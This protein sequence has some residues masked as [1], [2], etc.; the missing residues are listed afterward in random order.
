MLKKIK[1]RSGRHQ[2]DEFQRWVGVKLICEWFINPTLDKNDPPWLMEEIGVREYGIFDD[3]LMYKDSE[4]NFFQI[5]H[6]LS[7]I[8]DTIEL[9]DLNKENKKSKI[10]IDEMYSSYKKIQNKIESNSFNLIIYSNKSI[11]ST[12]KKKI[13][14]SNGCFDINFKMGNLKDSEKI[15]IR[16]DFYDLCGKPE[17]FEKFLDKLKFIKS[18]FD[19]EL[20]SKKISGLDDESINV[21]YSLVDKTT[22]EPG[23]KV[24]YDSPI[25]QRLFGLYEKERKNPLKIGIFSYHKV[26]KGES[27][28]YSLNL[29]YLISDEI[30]WNLIRNDLEKLKKNIDNET[31][32]RY[33]IIHA[34]VQLTIGYMIGFIFRRTTGYLISMHQSY[35][36]ELWDLLDSKKKG[37]IKV[38]TK[39]GVRNS[40]NLIIM[41]NIGDND[42]ENPVKNY[43]RENNITP[44]FFLIFERKN[45]IKKKEIKS[46]ID[47]IFSNIKKIMKKGYNKIHIFNAMPLSMAVFLGYESNVIT[48][49]NLYEFNKIEKKYY[50]SYKLQ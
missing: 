35:N 24:K 14:R 38:R 43:T 37:K 34:K 46:I 41:I 49:I 20:E 10:T 48:P 21:I 16:N 44:G 29:N 19:P 7:L 13:I 18:I 5:K 12:L 47:K 40:R 23:T 27:F 25:L 6:T 28:D 36:D 22:I 4:Y 15:R 3:I 39:K 42:L 9:S 45:L 50:K 2:G 1:S 17:D 32:I 30:D 31:D 26:P 33:L 11:D 8:G